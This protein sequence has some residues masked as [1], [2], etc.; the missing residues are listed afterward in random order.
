MERGRVRERGEC[1]VWN[2]E[3]LGNKGRSWGVKG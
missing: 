3:K 2:G 1:R